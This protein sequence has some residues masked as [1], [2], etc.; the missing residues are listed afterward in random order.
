MDVLRVFGNNGAH[1]G[2]IDLNDGGDTVSP[3]SWCS[4]LSWRTSSLASERQVAD[5][6]SQLPEG[7]RSAITRRDN[8]SK[9]SGA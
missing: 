4:T 7:A 2:E 6:F 3:C 1:I 8:K 9:V 5:L